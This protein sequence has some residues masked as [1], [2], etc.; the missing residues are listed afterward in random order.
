MDF[1]NVLRAVINSPTSAIRR[2]LGA[3]LENPRSWVWSVLSD[4]KR[5]SGIE[6]PELSAPAQNSEIVGKWTLGFSTQCIA[7][8]MR[9]TMR[10]VVRMNAVVAS[11]QV[12]NGSRWH[13]CNVT[14]EPL[15]VKEIEGWIM[16]LLCSN[17]DCEI[18]EPCL[19]SDW[20][21]QTEIGLSRQQLVTCRRKIPR[22]ISERGSKRCC[23]EHGV[24]VVINWKWW[25]TWVTWGRRDCGH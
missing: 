9:C 19:G 11:M 7:I 6:K 3:W 16:C 5:F 25:W 17:M 23:N 24:I 1:E 10:R 4:Q 8:F 15:R 2:G 18:Y 20:N 22:C 12:L 13:F 21:V 14:I